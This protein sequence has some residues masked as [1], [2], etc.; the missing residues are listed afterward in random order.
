MHMD[1][2]AAQAAEELPKLYPKSWEEYYRSAGI[3]AECSAIAQANK[4]L[5][6]TQRQENTEAYARRTVELLREAMRHG[7]NNARAAE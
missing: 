1:V 6:A 5:S 4:K 2:E 7:L 3:I